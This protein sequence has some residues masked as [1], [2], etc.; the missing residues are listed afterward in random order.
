MRIHRLK[1][2]ALIEASVVCGALVARAEPAPF[3]AYGAELGLLFQIVD[4]IL[5]EGSDGEPSY[6]NTLGP[7]ACAGAGGRDARAGASSCWRRSRAT[8]PSCAGL[9][10]V[11]ATRTA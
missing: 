2:G 10:E 9:T 11:V 4:D 5:D 6:V 3:R 7:R 1:T 8:R